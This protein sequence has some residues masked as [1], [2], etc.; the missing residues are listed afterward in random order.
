VTEWRLFDGDSPHV[1]TFAFHEHRERA[2]HLEQEWHRARLLRTAELVRSLAPA[3][4]V[5]LGCGDGGLLSLLGGIDAWGYDFQPSNQAAWAERGVHAEFAD[6]F[7]SDSPV[8]WAQVAVLTEVLEHLADPHGVLA[9]IARHVEYVVA[10]SPATETGDAHC[11]EH[12]W[13]WDA[14]GYRSLFE[15]HFEVTHHE[16]VDWSQLVVARSK[17]AS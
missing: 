1:S 7:A 6:V 3:S 8:A 16:R 13:A 10:S 17:A 4:V 15:T 14:A 9:R 2:P 5:D 12:A 11:A